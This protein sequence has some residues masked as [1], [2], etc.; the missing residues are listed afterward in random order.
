[1]NAGS[2]LSILATA[3]TFG[4]PASTAYSLLRRYEDTGSIAP[5]PRGG[6]R[7]KKLTPIALTSLAEWIEGRPDLTLGQLSMKL[8]T[9]HSIT[10]S[11]KAISKALTKLGFTVKLLRVIPISRNCPSVVQ[12]RKIYAQKY[13]SE[14]PTDNRNIIW[15]DETGFNLHIRRKYGRAR[16]GHR[17]SISV[18]NNRGSNISVCAAMSCE[19]FLHERLRPGAYNAASFCEFLNELFVLLRTTGRSQCWLIVDNARFHHCEIVNTCAAHEGHVLTFLPPYSPMLNPIESLFGKWKSLIRTQNVALTRDMLLLSMA[20]CRY[21]I[22]R[23]DCLGF[24][25]EMNR[26]IG[27]SLQEHIFE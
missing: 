14:A 9:V 15:I 13:L 18:A 24:I 21:E 4:I 2:N 7:A 10:I 23:D 11:P 25:R 20:A 22:S 12:A 3:K 1:M 5:Q 26:D 19:G 16:T 17:A 6:A 27:L 8:A